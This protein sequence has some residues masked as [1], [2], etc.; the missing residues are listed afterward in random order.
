[1]KGPF[2][3]SSRISAAILRR[4]VVSPCI[5]FA[6]NVLVRTESLIEIT[7]FAGP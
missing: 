2:F 4:F 3:L 7:G 1:L 5:A 6:R